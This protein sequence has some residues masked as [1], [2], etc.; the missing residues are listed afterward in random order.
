MQRV[1]VVTVP[2]TNVAANMA[3][4]AMAIPTAATAAKLARVTTGRIPTNATAVMACVAANTVIVALAKPIV[5]LVAK[6]GL[7][8]MALITLHL[9]STATALRLI[10]AVNMGIVAL[11]MHIVAMAASQ[12]LA[13]HRQTLIMFL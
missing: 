5:A 13:L 7:V 8:T 9:L 4:A 3:I 1:E 12:V 6:P 2:Q 10:V 11:V